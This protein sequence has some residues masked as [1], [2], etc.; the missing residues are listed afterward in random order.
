MKFNLSIKLSKSGHENLKK[1]NEK[2][3]KFY[4]IFETVNSHH[5]TVAAVKAAPVFHSTA[6][7]KSIDDIRV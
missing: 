7:L 6:N 2:C 5:E 4:E 1:G 3:Q